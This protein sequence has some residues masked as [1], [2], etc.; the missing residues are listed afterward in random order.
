[1]SNLEIDSHKGL[2]NI[3]IKLVSM[4]LIT[5]FDGSLQNVYLHIK[6]IGQY[7]FYALISLSD[8]ALKIQYGS[9]SGYI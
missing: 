9:G 1:M 8:S 5:T 6:N 3:I 7:I 2:C 4:C